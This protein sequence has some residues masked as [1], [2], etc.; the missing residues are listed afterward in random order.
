MPSGWSRRNALLLARLVAGRAELLPVL[1]CSTVS[2]VW[3]IVGSRTCAALRTFEVLG[4]YPRPSFTAGVPWQPMTDERR[5]RD[6]AELRAAVIARR[7]TPS[8]PGDEAHGETT[9]LSMGGFGAR[10]DGSYGTGDVIDADLVLDASV[11]RLRALVV[12]VSGEGV[13]QRVHCAFSEPPPAVRDAIA[14]F[15]AKHS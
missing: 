1:S 15:L 4:E 3:P 11:V 10:L 2:G 6:R 7:I 13:Y 12:G 14:A 5:G 9:D 8:G